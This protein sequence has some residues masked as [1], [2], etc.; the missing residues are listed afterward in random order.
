MNILIRTD[1]TAQCVYGEALPLKSLG[2]VETRRASHV[3]PTA[4]G[5]W[6]ADLSPIGGPILGPFELRSTALAAELDWLDSFLFP[7]SLTAG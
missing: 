2:T 3:E 4:D 1:G 7:P 5:A 6:T